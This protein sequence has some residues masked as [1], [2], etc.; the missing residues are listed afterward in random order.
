MNKGIAIKFLK[1]KIRTLQRRIDNDA[2]VDKIG[3]LN[4]I[5]ILRNA[6]LV[7]KGE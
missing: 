5:Q 4:N 2:Y 6:I 1:N 7:L 3:L